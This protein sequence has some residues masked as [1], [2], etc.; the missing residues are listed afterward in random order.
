MY[1]RFTRRPNPM[2][3]WGHA[4]FAADRD[5]IMGCYGD[6]EWIYSGDGAAD[7][8]D[9]RIA[10]VQKWDED[11]E[12]GIAPIGY[13]DLTGEEVAELFDPSDIVESAAAWD[14][15]EAVAWFW[16]R[17]ADPMGIPAVITADGAIVFDAALIEA[18]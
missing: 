7:V 2:S 18:A 11:L 8:S 1:S 14:C 15:A 17:I 3:D 5:S 16:D 12:M 9:L 10:I 13:E 4:M 6:H